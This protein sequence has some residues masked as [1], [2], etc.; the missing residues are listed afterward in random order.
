MEPG[1]GNFGTRNFFSGNGHVREILPLL[2]PNIFSLLSLCKETKFKNTSVEIS[3]SRGR[4]SVFLALPRFNSY[5]GMHAQSWV[6]RIK[7]WHHFFG[8]YTF[9]FRFVLSFVLPPRLN[10]AET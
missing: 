7:K 1:L 5:S 9:W 8:I 10:L 2:V 3:S 6:L 4:K